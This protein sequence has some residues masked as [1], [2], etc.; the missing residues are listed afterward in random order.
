[1]ESPR[2]DEEESRRTD[3]EECQDVLDE[4][5]DVEFGCAKILFVVGLNVLATIIIVTIAWKID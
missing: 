4:I 1:M 3:E 5:R 2:T